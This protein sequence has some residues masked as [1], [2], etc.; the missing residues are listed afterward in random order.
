MLILFE[1][2]KGVHDGYSG[3]RIAVYI[4]TDKHTLLLRAFRSNTRF[5]LVKIGFAQKQIRFSVQRP[6][7]FLQKNRRRHS[8]S[9]SSLIAVDSLAFSDNVLQRPSVP[10]IASSGSQL[11]GPPS[12]SNEKRPRW[13]VPAN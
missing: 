7:V 8:R 2:E 11:L 13:R 5:Q 12:T 1:F 3:P 9:S 4:L 10:T 6:A